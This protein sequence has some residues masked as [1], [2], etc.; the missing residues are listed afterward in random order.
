MPLSRE[1]LTDDSFKD[2]LLEAQPGAMTLMDEAAFEASRRRILD[3]AEDTGA[4]WVFAAGSL[5]WN[6]IIEV[7]ERRPATL[8]GYARSFCVW[9]TNG[10]GSPEAP[11]L[12]LG[13]EPEEGGRAEGV[14]LRIERGS[15]EEE[16]LILWRREMVSGV[17]RPAWVEAETPDGPVHAVA[18]LGEPEHER[19]AGR[20]PLAEQAEAI[21][22]GEGPLGTNRDYLFSIVERLGEAGMGDAYLDDLAA[23]VRQR[24]R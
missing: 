3:A 15:W 13:L 23:R 24:C 21:A 10:R 7:A 17:Y 9:A 12:W 5:I 14:A 22:R 2:R 8:H 6:P 4:L 19:Y 1:S 18:F 16:T 11:G 20:L